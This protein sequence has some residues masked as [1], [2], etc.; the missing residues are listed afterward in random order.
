MATSR[1]GGKGTRG[2]LFR[3][4]E[5]PNCRGGVARYSALR[6]LYLSTF[7]CYCP[8]GEA[9]P[10]TGCSFRS[11]SGLSAVRALPGPQSLAEN[12]FCLETLQSTPMTTGNA[13]VFYQVFSKNPSIFRLQLLLFLLGFAILIVVSNK[14]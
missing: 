1:I 7:R 9:S 14:E 11:S 13:T 2:Y 5:A 12:H 3:A 10:S 6:C 8:S 4:R